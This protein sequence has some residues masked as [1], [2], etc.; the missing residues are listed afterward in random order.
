MSRT[1]LTELLT[2]LVNAGALTLADARALVAYA[3]GLRAGEDVDAAALPQ[4]DA[5]A[6][7]ALSLHVA[8]VRIL[9][10]YAGRRRITTGQEARAL[11]TVD[12][13][14]LARRVRLID[15]VRADDV[16]GALSRETV[17]RT[18]VLLSDA[19]TATFGPGAAGSARRSAGD[20]T[21][22]R[23]AVSQALAEDAATLARLGAG[24]DLTGAQELRLAR[25]QARHADYVDAFRFEG[26]SERQVRAAVVRQSGPSRTMFFE[27]AAEKEAGPMRFPVYRYRPQLEASGR[28]CRPCLA[29]A[30]V[31]LIGQGPMPSSVC[32]G[33]GACRCDIEVF[34]DP[35]EYARLR[36]ATRQAA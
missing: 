24:G 3:D 26:L 25:A 17:R 5:R 28:T 22:W 15:A 8:V 11:A 12:R 6:T 16:R 27:N 4:V 23:R 19:E 1:R 14:P 34:D 30:G 21:R 20:V 13:L 7:L 31:Y 29:A 36:G 33:G 10:A 9:R 18:V 2:A 35:A 32:L